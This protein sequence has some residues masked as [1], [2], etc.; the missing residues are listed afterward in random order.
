MY[1]NS[2]GK[3]CPSRC[4]FRAAVFLQTTTDATVSHYFRKVCFS[5]HLLGHL[6]HSRFV[7]STITNCALRPGVHNMVCVHF[8][9]Y[10]RG[11][12]A[13]GAATIPEEVAKHSMPMYMADL[14]TLHLLLLSVFHSNHIAI[15]PIGTKGIQRPC[16]SF[17]PREFQ[18]LWSQRQRYTSHIT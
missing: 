12:A 1:E 4:L 18:A 2:V 15:L 9:M 11:K 10:I 14:Q 7:P 17:T 8:G 3:K 13:E 5:A 16:R 6:A